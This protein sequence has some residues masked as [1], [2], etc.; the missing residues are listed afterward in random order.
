[1]RSFAIGLVLLTLV[2]VTV[3]SLRPG[4]FRQQLR[5]AGR[6]LRILLVLGGIYVAASTVVRLALPE[7]PIADYGLPV[8]AIVLAL[9][10]VFIGRDP[11]PSPKRP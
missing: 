7:G 3:L 10:F 1:V 6:R 9:V 4:G 8:L 2:S 11:A 5:M